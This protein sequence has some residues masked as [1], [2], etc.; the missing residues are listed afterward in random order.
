M[1]GAK[2]DIKAASSSEVSDERALAK[3]SMNFIKSAKPFVRK[4]SVGNCNVEKGINSNLIYNL[5]KNFSLSNFLS[6]ENL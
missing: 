6:N 5:L 4:F 1:R 3:L 2:F